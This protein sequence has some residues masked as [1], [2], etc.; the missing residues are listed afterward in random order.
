MKA[1]LRLLF[2]SCYCNL[3]LLLVFTKISSQLRT[4]THPYALTDTHTHTHT[5]KVSGHQFLSSTHPPSFLPPFLPSLSLSLCLSLSH[6]LSLCL[7]LSLSHTL[8]LSLSLSISLSLSLFFPGEQQTNSA[9]RSQLILANSKGPSALSY[10]RIIFGT[11]GR[12]R[13]QYSEKV[14]T[15]R[16]LH[17]PSPALYLFLSRV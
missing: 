4:H 13:P 7:S 17:L 5:F 1:V 6:S 11:D 14:R 3:A 16:A 8:S 2:F 15:V 9:A 12:V 10:R